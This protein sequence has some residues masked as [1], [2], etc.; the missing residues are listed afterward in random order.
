[1]RLWVLG[2][3]SRGNA[4]LLECG[5]DR[6]LV[7]AGFSV[8]TLQARL[9]ATGVAPE[10]IA[11]CIVT[12]EHTDHVRGACAA[13]A[14]WGW[15]LYASEGTVRAHPALRDAD[16]R[17]FE[18]GGTVM[19][20]GFSL[21][22]VR[23]PHDA[24][25]PVAVIATATRTGARAGVCYDLGHAPDTVLAALRD[26]DLLVLEANHDEGMLRMGPYPASV[27]DRIAGRHGHL[28]NRA[29]AAVARGTASPSLRHVV[30]AHLSE[31]C[32]D[33]R[34]ATADVS[35]ALA[36]GRARPRVSAASQDAVAGPFSPGAARAEQFTLGL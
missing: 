4:V 27:C 18:A 31:S 19:V 6:V 30:L 35:A 33:A 26:L 1:V 15:S 28:S 23:T 29:A 17:T 24:E 10:S 7:D 5:R 36:K 32:N 9:H 8:R 12:H 20:D 21:A 2:S 14:K 25:E 11:S 16:V 22:T 3:G 34:V 13:S